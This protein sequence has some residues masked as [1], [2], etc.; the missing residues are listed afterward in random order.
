MAKN[1]S[2]KSDDLYNADKAVKDFCKNH[3][4]NLNSDEHRILGRLL[5]NRAQAMSKVFGIRIHS[6]YDDDDD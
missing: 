2:V 6:I 5:E 3:P 1:N 4:D